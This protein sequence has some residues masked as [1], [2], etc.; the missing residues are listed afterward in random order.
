MAKPRPYV[1]LSCAM[2]ADG[3]IDDATDTRLLL[4]N[5]DD[6]DRVDGER[7]ASDAILVGANTIRRDNPR[8]LV[9]S[10]ARRAERARRGLPPSPAKVTITGSGDLSADRQF[11]AAGGPDVARLVY[12][13]TSALPRA[14]DQLGALPGVELID[15]GE[16]PSLAGALAD[17]AARG[18]RRLLAEGGTAIHTQLLA[19]GLADELQL[20]VAPF[21]VGDGGAPRFVGDAAFPFNAGHRMTLAE[22]TPI[23][24]VALLRYVMDA[25]SASAPAA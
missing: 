19:D 22:V 20:V 21:F 3:Y 24:D 18:V 4:S 16:P 10:E 8:L 6:F 12:C 11:F 17:L 7:A 1:V 15:G 9:R 14:A 2:S 13:A 25:D 5:D 23:G